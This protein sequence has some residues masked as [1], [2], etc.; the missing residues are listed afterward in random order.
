MSEGV[1]L[2]LPLFW[3][4]LPA[5]EAQEQDQAHSLCVHSHHLIYCLYTL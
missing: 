1:T 3:H 2:K 5:A 4:H